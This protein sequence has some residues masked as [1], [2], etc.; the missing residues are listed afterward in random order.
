MAWPILREMIRRHRRARIAALVLEL[1]AW[2]RDGR[3]ILA[4]LL[5]LTD[6]EED[7]AVECRRVLQQ[8]DG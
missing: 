4:A 1:E 2:E 8:L 3:G 5:E 6:P 7:L